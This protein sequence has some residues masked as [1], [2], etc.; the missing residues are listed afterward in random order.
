MSHGNY[1][2][3]GDGVSCLFS[4]RQNTFSP[5]FSPRLWKGGALQAAEKRLGADNHPGARRATPPE[6]GGELPK[7]LPS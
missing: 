6:S 2:T 3:V 4:H 7:M 5:D 1:A